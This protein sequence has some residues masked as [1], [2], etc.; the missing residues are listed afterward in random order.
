MAKP[1]NKSITAIDLKEYLESDD[2]FAF[3]LKVLTICNQHGDHVFHG[4]TYQDPNLNKNRQFDIR[5]WI[6]N[7]RRRLGLA[8]ECKNLK[9]SYPLLVSQLPRTKKEAFHSSITAGI[10]GAHTSSH[11]GSTSIYPEGLFVG[12]ST[13]QVG[14][15]AQRSPNGPE[16]ITGDAEVHDKWGQA[17]ASAKDLITEATTYRGPHSSGSE[18]NSIVIPI[19]VIPDE[20]LWTVDYSEIGNRVGDPKLSNSCTL[21]LG[22]LYDYQVSTGKGKY[23]IS[24]LNIYTV[25]GF[26]KFLEDAKR[27]MPEW[28]VLSQD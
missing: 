28:F 25:R 2:D 6:L 23:C 19:L 14:K 11:K 15:P 8:V 1:A 9:P 10:F 20:T 3:E 22:S 7:D 27:G 13:T 18:Q 4:G 16:F 24:H 21:Y 26:V 17:M 12:K 5:M